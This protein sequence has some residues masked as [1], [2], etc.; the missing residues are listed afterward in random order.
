MYIIYIYTLNFSSSSTLGFRRGYIGY[1]TFKR[2]NKK[3]KK[4]RQRREREKGKGYEYDRTKISWNL[5]WK[6]VEVDEEVVGVIIVTIVDCKID[7]YN[8][9]RSI[10]T[11]LFVITF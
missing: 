6:V 9:G 10:F 7:S 2:Y 3:K 5:R 4:K 8:H 1:F 11:F